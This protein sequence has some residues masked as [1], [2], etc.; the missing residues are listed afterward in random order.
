MPRLWRP[1]RGRGHRSESGQEFLLTLVVEVPYGPS[2]E[3]LEEMTAREDGLARVPA[4]AAE[5]VR[6]LPLTRHPSDQTRVR[7]TGVSSAATA[8]RS[9]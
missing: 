8:R 7:A 2:G 5:V 3:T 4:A 6:S 9:P 1:A